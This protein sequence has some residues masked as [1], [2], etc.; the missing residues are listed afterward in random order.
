[1]LNCIMSE[2]GP[3]AFKSLTAQKHGLQIARDMLL[4]NLEV[5][6]FRFIPI[7]KFIIDVH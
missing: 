3:A 1:M 5:Y 7:N 6:R 2:A 4:L